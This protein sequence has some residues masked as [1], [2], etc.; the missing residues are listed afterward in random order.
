V[1]EEAMQQRAKLSAH[2]SATRERILQAWRAETRADPVQTTAGALTRVQFDDHIP[3]LLDA[4]N[5]K[6]CARRESAGAMAADEAKAQEDIKHGLQ[7]WQQGYRLEEVM[8]EWGH[9]HLCLSREVEAFF[10]AHADITRETMAI[11]HEEL[12][13]LISEGVNHSASQYA[14]MQ[15]AEAADRVRDLERALAEW[16][17][18]E[19]HRSILMHQAVHDLRANVQSVSSAAQLLGEA[20]LAETERAEFARMIQHEVSSVSA[21]LGELMALA[22]LEAGHENRHV[23]AFD[24]AELLHSLCES[25]RPVALANQLY[26]RDEGPSALPVEGDAAKVRRILQN[27]IGNSLKYTRW[28]GVHVRWGS[29]AKSWWVTVTDTGPGLGGT[30]IVAGLKEATVISQEVRRH[31][32][33]ESHG[34]PRPSTPGSSRPR[35]QPAGE[36]IGLSIVKRL[37]ELLDARLEVSSTGTGTTFRVVLPRH[38]E[39]S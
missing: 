31:A 11:V 9:L 7:R 38:Y 6:L 13:Q 36:G 14:R 22:R 34:L 35:S 25:A 5:R 30:E 16:E 1:T 15:Q 20:D 39:R 29:E 26:L 27:L 23:G 37:C 28:G 8:H 3:Q 24:A 10:A 2:L 32:G 18:G 12:I 4:F 19:R 17:T 33:S 21:M